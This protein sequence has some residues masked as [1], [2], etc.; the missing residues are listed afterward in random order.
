MRESEVTRQQIHVD[1]ERAA[2]SPFHGTIAR[3]LPNG[4]SD[5]ECHDCGAAGPEVFV[6]SD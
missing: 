4:L 6:T 2:E 1:P 5:F 3:G